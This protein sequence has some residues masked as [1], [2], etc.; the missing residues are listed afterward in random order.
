MRFIFVALLTLCGLHPAL[1][2]PDEHVVKLASL[3]WPPYASA[4]VSAGGTV[5]DTVRRALAASGYRLVVEYFPWPKAVAVGE[6]AKGFAGYFPSYYSADRA[7]R[8]E[9]SDPV[10]ESPL[11]F[12]QRSD[13]PSTW[14]TIEDLKAL[15][16]GVV[17]GYINTTA[18]D[19]RIASGDQPADSTLD[20]A[21]NLMKLAAGR[22]DLAVV[23]S[24]VFANLMGND[25]RLTGL[26][27]Q[28]VM[29]PRLLE[30]KSVHV[31]FRKTSEGRKLS[32]ALSEGLRKIGYQPPVFNQDPE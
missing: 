6:S 27:G 23:D 17:E 28:L 25:T 4:S 8:T 2:A 3:E 1:A 11:G 32:R 12:A 16:I 18:L 21:S 7:R 5:T 13:S 24:K 30:L 10:G 29:N 15:R 26:R 19:R 14:V 9:L 22:V 20:D 31:A